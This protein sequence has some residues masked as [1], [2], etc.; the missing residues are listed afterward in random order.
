MVI[1]FNGNLIVEKNK[2]PF[3]LL[4]LFNSNTVTAATNIKCILYTELIIFL[5]P[6][7]VAFCRKLYK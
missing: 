4:I 3:R 7:S 5:T 1:I 6:K 2:E